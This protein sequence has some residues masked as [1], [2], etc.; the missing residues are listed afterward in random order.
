MGYE[1]Q[2]MDIK[3]RKE[4]QTPT[5]RSEDSHFRPSSGAVMGTERSLDS[6]LVGNCVTSSH[7][8]AVALEE[9]P[10]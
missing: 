8:S 5:D 4:A 1:T 7:H 2:K 6:P 10:V 3:G 9:H